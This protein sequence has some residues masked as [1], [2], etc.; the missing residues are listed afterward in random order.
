MNALTLFA[1]KQRFIIGLILTIL[2]LGIAAPVVYGQQNNEGSLNLVVSPLTVPLEAKPGS[3]VSTTLK[4]KNGGTSNERVKISVLKFSAEGQDG[5]PKLEDVSDKDDFI[6]W[7]T[8]SEQSFTAEPNV[9][10]DIKMTVSVPQTAAFGYY[11][12]IVFSREGAEQS[13]QPQKANL[14]G[15]VAT[16]ALLD[17]QAPGAKRETKLTEFSMPK[18]V[19]EFLPADF[20]VAM[21]NTGNVHVAPRGNIFISKGGKQVALLEV[22]LDKGY[23]LPNSTRKFTTNWQDGSPVYRIKEVDGKAVL[24]KNGRQQKFLDWSNFNP[25][26]VRFGK[27]TAR[28]VMVHNDGVRDVPVEGTITFWV[29]PWRIIGAI[30]LVLVVLLAGIYALFG[31]PIKSRV[32]KLLK[33]EK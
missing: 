18:K 20:T 7:V 9:W 14:L 29:I 30:L 23:I 6:K 27:F 12:A 4:V 32:K 21:E 5:T 1:Q 3:V 25:S 11:Y 33:K 16:L 17:V 2:V 28:V 8:F 13:I 15:A 31:K 22:N 24:D 19:Y 26:K 10:K